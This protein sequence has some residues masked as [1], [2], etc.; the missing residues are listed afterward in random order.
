VITIGICTLG[1]DGGQS[2]IGQYVVSLLEEFSRIIS[3]SRT[4]LDFE[5]IAHVSE[6]PIFLQRAASLR[7]HSVADSLRPPIVNVVWHLTALPA[8][9]RSRRYDVL[10]LPAGNRR[11]PLRVP[12]PSVGT[13]H[14]FSSLHVREKYDRWRVL[15]IRRVLPVLI[16]RLSRIITVSD[17]SRRD[18]VDY[19]G[20]R[21]AAVSVVP[22]GVDHAVYFPANRDDALQHVAA[23]YGIRPP[24]VLYVSRLEHPGKNHVR[25]IRA[26]D[27]LKA[28]GDLPHQLVIAGSDWSGAERIHAAAEQAAAREA[29]RFTGYVQDGDMPDLYRAANL[30][31]FPSLYEGFGLPVIEAM[32]CGTPVVCANRSSLPEVAGDAAMMFDPFDEVALQTSI[33]TMLRDSQIA[34]KY[35][36]RGLARAAAFSWKRTAERTIEVLIDAAATG[37]ARVAG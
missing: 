21:V 28:A 13:I 36:Q 3:S 30:L 24:F 11:L 27:R 32:A 35:R 6:A 9:C 5:V 29:I 12:C 18:L 7:A 15:Y 14:D 2:G 31:V 23:K 25:L 16:R 4:D 19:A 22:N 33:S 26:F 8:L 34:A 1:C 17:C 10:F 37:K 20:A